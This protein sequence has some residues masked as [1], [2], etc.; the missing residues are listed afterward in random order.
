MF[1]EKEIKPMK[2][3]ISSYVENRH[4]NNDTYQKRVLPT[5]RQ[6]FPRFKS[7]MLAYVR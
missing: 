7:G 6:Y 3:P 1:L 4:E 2:Q 5:R